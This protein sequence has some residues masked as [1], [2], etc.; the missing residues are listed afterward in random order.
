MAKYFKK[1]NDKIIELLRFGKLCITEYIIINNQLNSLK[2]KS[3]LEI[4]LKEYSEINLEE[5]LEELGKIN[6]KNI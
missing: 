3:N 5:Y 6:I 4:N 2:T 1:V